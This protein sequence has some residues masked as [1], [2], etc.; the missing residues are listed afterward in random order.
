MARK[1]KTSLLWLTALAA[2]F[3]VWQAAVNDWDASRI[4]VE[5]DVPPEAEIVYWDAKPESSSMLSP[6]ESLDVEVIFQFDVTAFEKYVL[7]ARRAENWRTLPIPD[8]CFPPHSPRY[9]LTVSPVTGLF[10]CRTAGDNIMR[11]T[12]TIRGELDEPVND[13][14]LG[15]LDFDQRQLIVKVRTRN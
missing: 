11:A 4:R 6:R 5:F 14:M 12:K 13:F 8:D 7:S 10:Q 3:C 9:K 2:A 15:I 1:W